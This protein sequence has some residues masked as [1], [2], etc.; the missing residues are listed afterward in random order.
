MLPSQIFHSVRGV[1]SAGSPNSMSSVSTE[2]AW[3]KMTEMGQA[4][5]GVVD[6]TCC[7]WMTLKARRCA[8]R[9]NH[10]LSHTHVR[11]RSQ[12]CDQVRDTDKHWEKCACD[13]VLCLHIPGS[14]VARPHR[15]M[16]IC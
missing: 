9:P 3:N 2:V 8:T 1:Q 7:E 5:R 12:R 14:E 13:E 11:V 10:V 6:D 4:R 15:L 16:N